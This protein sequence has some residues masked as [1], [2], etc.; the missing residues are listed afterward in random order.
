MNKTV[1]EM[2]VEELEQAIAKKKQ[3]EKNLIQPLDKPDF[4]RLIKTLEE[5]VLEI[6]RKGENFYDDDHIRHRLYE[7]AL[8]AVY[9]KDVWSWLRKMET[10]PEDD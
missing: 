7:D 3:S 1:D 6:K 4:S 8:V 10:L 9:G 5:Y 2:S